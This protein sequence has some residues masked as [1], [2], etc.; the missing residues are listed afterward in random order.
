MDNK[1]RNRAQLITEAIDGFS[2]RPS[3]RDSFFKERTK[4]RSQ[5][6]RPGMAHMTR[7]VR[8]LV[9][10]QDFDPASNPFTRPTIGKDAEATWFDPN[11]QA[12]MAPVFK[13]R[14]VG[15][16]KGQLPPQFAKK[17]KTFPP[18]EDVL[19]QDQE[20]SVQDQEAIAQ[21]N[22]LLQQ[23]GLPPGQIT[24]Q[25]A[26]SG[27]APPELPEL[28]RD[29]RKDPSWEGNRAAKISNGV[30]TFSQKI[31]NRYGIDSDPLTLGGP[32]TFST[33]MRMAQVRWGDVTTRARRRTN[34]GEQV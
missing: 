11:P 7:V 33:K 20:Q 18:Q 27:A 2:L 22:K 16:A 12:R 3:L 31:T 9:D 15:E 23:Q 1:T 24:P 5:S 21:Q 34:N 17:K 19:R 10:N 14:L 4:F 29:L 8:D 30:Q 6:S 25:D 28:P 32:R 13:K 26:M